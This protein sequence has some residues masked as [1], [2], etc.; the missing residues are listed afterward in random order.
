MP[1]R[2]TISLRKT[3]PYRLSPTKQRQRLLDQQLEERRWPYN[4]LLAERRAGWEQRQD[5]VRLYDQHAAAP[6]L[7]AER[8]TVAGGH[9]QVA[10]NVAVR[11]ER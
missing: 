3:F 10:Q 4:H 11:L 2:H 8:P 1:Y 6:A 5:S 9:S 7:K